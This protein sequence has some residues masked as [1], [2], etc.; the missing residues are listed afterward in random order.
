MEMKPAMMRK[1]YKEGD[2]LRGKFNRNACPECGRKGCSCAYSQDGSVLG[3]LA[4]RGVSSSDFA[5]LLR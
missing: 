3:N 5:I 2:V 4:C 1:N